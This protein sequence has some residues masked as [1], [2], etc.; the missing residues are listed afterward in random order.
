[1]HFLKSPFIFSVLL[2]SISKP[3]LHNLLTDYHR[4]CSIN[5]TKDY[6]TKSNYNSSR[7]CTINSTG[8]SSYTSQKQLSAIISWINFKVNSQL[9]LQFISSCRN[10]SSLFYQN[11]WYSLDLVQKSPEIFLWKSWMESLRNTLAN[12]RKNLFNV[13]LRKFSLENPWNCLV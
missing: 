1:M 5:F 13:I 6:S 2:C 4:N 11:Q 10:L 3:L 8:V 12:F 9:I 7:N